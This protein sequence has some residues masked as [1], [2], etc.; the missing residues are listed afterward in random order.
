MRSIQVDKRFISEDDPRMDGLLIY[1]VVSG[2][3]GVRVMTTRSVF[4]NDHIA[5]LL[6]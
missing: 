6:A 3:Q 2:T 1:V 4:R 5:S